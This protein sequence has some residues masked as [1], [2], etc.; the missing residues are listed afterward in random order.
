[1]QYFKF[2]FITLIV[3]LCFCSCSASKVQRGQ[4]QRF[5][6]LRSFEIRDDTSLLVKESTENRELL[7]KVLK[8]GL[9]E[10]G[11]TF[12]DAPCS[13]DATMA[14]TVRVYGTGY[15]R[16]LSLAVPSAHRAV[17]NFDVEVFDKTPDAPLL[18]KH[19]IKY[20]ARTDMGALL[21]HLIEH[22]LRHYFG[23]R[24]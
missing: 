5:H 12:C 18:F 8:A 1:M 16:A 23:R 6:S 14:I 9:T 4:E 21:R 2:S 10:F 24:S 7:F 3:V 20:S 11:Y 22:M 13:A 17:L 15:G 19:N